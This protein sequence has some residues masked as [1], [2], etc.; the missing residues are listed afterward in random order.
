MD[1]KRI[2]KPLKE[3]S[4]EQIREILNKNDID[5]LIS[6]PLSVGEHHIN[7]KYAQDIC[8]KLSKHENPLVRANAVLGFAYIARTKGKLEKHIVKPIVLY[9]LRE[10]QEFQ[11][12]IIDA[13]NDINLFMKWKIGAKSTME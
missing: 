11:W 10:N 4:N 5:E 8:A 6:L 9:E 12:R 7:W 2:Y 1:E 13:I 3:L